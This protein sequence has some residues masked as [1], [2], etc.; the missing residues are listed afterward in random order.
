MD[1]DGGATACHCGGLPHSDTP[2]SK[3]D[4]SSP[5]RFAACRV[6]HR[7]S[8]PRHPP[9]ALCSLISS[10]NSLDYNMR[11]LTKVS[12]RCACV[13]LEVSLCSCQSAGGSESLPKEN[14][15]TEH[16]LKRILPPIVT[17]SSLSRHLVPRHFYERPEGRSRLPR[18]AVGEGIL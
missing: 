13:T 12:T 14:L 17:N 18:K 3:L 4:C 10:P 7:P 15:R 16:T 6:L 2:G 1:S 9:C 11:E 8:A 5:R